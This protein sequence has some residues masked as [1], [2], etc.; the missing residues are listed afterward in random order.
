MPKATA[1]AKALYG[2]IKASISAAVVAAAATANSI[3]LCVCVL[4]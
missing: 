1:K 2:K 4:L 3:R